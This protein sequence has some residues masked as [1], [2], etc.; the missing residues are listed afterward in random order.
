M[1]L[2][3]GGL[4]CFNGVSDVSSIKFR[5]CLPMKTVTKRIVY[6]C[7]NLMW[8]QTSKIKQSGNHFKYQHKGLPPETLNVA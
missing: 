3:Q 1:G 8:T 6:I 7:F 2:Q 4:I 5:F